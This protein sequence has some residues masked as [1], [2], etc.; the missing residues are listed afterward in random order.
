MNLH[1]LYARVCAKRPDL[2]VDADD[3]PWTLAHAGT[4]WDWLCHS[5]DDD[6]WR[7]DDLSDTHAAALILAR[8]VEALP[9]SSMLYRDK[10]LWRVVQMRLP[11][12]KNCDG[13]FA[14]SPIEALAAFYL[15]D[16]Q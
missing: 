11:F 13:P 9:E 3:G 4:E 8:W 5:I 6:V 16:A 12:S 10:D 2:A 7:C 15:G 1:D 14:A